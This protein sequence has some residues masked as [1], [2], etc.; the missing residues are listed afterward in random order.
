MPCDLPYSRLLAVK[1]YVSD[2]VGI[3]S[4]TVYSHWL[5]IGHAALTLK[6]EEMEVC[7]PFAFPVSAL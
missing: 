5:K 7:A 4:R 1:C 2:P 6:T 3:V